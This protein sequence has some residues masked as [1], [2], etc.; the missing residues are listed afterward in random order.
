MTIWDCKYCGST[1]MTIDELL[2]HISIG[3]ESDLVK[4]N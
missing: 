2:S 3:H 1:Y 4:V